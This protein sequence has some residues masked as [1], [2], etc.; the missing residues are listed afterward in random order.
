MKPSIDFFLAYT[1]GNEAMRGTVE[2]LSECEL[3][4]TLC[5]VGPYEPR[6]DEFPEADYETI[7]TD[8]PRSTKLLRAIS[9]KAE[10]EYTVLFLSPLTFIPGYRCLERLVQAAE[11]SGAVMVYSDRYDAN[12]PHPVIDYQAGSLRDDFDFGGLWLIRTSVFKAFFACERSRYKYA[13]LYALRL[14]L[15]RKGCLLHLPEMLY[16]EFETDFRKSGEKQ[17]DY[18]NPANREVQLEMERA[19][20][21]HLKRIE[22]WLAPDEYDD[23]PADATEY[24]VTASVVIPVRNRVSTVCDAVRS[25]LSQKADFDFN[26]IVVD[27]HSTDGTREA[28][29]KIAAADTRVVLLVP[30]R[31][32]LGI[33]GCWDFAIRSELCGRYAVQLDSDDL[34]SA[35]DTLLRI[36]EAFARQ[37]AAMVVGSY[38]MVDNNLETLAP[39]LIS[40]REWTQ[41]N[42]RNNA[43]R[44]NGLG[45]PRAFRTDVLRQVGFPNTS[46]GEDYAL[47]L[48]IS[49]RYRI[50]RIYDELYL[51]RRWEGNSDAALS[52]ERVNKNNL[53]KDTL[54]T[55][56]LKAR[57]CLVA[58]W[59]RRADA[60]EVQA[61]FERQME[62]WSEVA[63]RFEALEKDVQTRKLE[64]GNYALTVQYNPARMVSTAAKVDKRNLKKRPC[65]LCNH[66]RPEQQISLPVEGTLQVL[67]NPF[68]ILPGHLTIPTRRH[69]PQNLSKLLPSMLRLAWELPNLLVFYNGARCGASAPDHAHL[70]AGKRGIVPIERD[71]KLH[72][73]H[74]EK[75][76]PLKGEEEAELN[77]LGYVSKSVGLY[78]LKGY[79]CPAF[80]LRGGQPEG[81]GF[82][83]TKLLS[84]LPVDDKAAEPNVNMLAWREKG[85][86]GDTDNLVIVLFTRKKHRPD[87]Y[88]SEGKSQCLVSPGALDMGGLVITPREEDFNRMTPKMAAGILREVSHSEAEVAQIARKLHGG[89]L[90]KASEEGVCVGFEVNEEP[91]VSVGIMSTKEL[92]FELNTA[93]SA[94]GSSIS[95]MQMARC[96]DG[97]VEWNG[98]IYSE[99]LFTPDDEE[100]ASFTLKDVAIG[101]NFHWSRKE[102]QTFRGALR[103]I[104]DEEELVVINEVPVECYLESVISSEMNA[105]SSLELLKAHAVVSRSWVF[106]QMKQRRLTGTHTAGFFSFVRKGEELI[107]WYDRSDHMLFDVCADDHCQRY[108]GITRKTLSTVAQAVA[109]TTGT[110]LLSGES[111]VMRD[112]QNVAVVHLNATPPV[113]KT[114]R[115]F[116]TCSRCVTM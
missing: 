92:C 22:A 66:N 113:G 33:G 41:E 100:S 53:Y 105:H 45:A 68:P 29:A 37:K 3:V 83:I 82:L 81:E 62:L 35:S 40:H 59:N 95:G 17:F 91:N 15:S 48:A 18:V 13:A 67:V 94:K 71:W 108:Q 106:S 28:V 78:L 73:N 47:G 6:D 79:A 87:C 32:D 74:L 11:S 86:P 23:L 104:V 50:G 46:Y 14:H 103:L 52:V 84:V 56:E 75:L 69:T 65:F 63:V 98:N 16:T 77:E 8:A 9:Q 38:R 80:V 10:S 57:Q 44:I 1:P 112:S 93:F 70:Q 43:L 99:L 4:S 7:V 24:P 110:V 49:R 88:F 36:V 58:L 101:V 116:P 107:K 90:K 51:C 64:L 12:G 109:E 89:R 20:T 102:N 5:L 25:V 115:T 111:C 27:N 55:L 30:K 21:E 42:G 85:D 34:Y 97:G 76:Y 61:F 31:N 96:V 54:R 2:A 26:V 72:E 60:A 39:G 19:C 114:T